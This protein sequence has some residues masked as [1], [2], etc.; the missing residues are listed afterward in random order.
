MAQ[1]INNYSLQEILIFLIIL[2]LG[3]KG[4]FTFWDWAVDRL[5][6]IFHKEILILEKVILILV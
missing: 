2:A 5:R 1:L 4:F 6:K 3:I